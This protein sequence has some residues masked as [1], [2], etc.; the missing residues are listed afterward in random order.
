MAELRQY[1][2]AGKQADLESAIEWELAQIRR[3]TAPARRPPK[4]VYGLDDGS[5]MVVVDTGEMQI[6]MDRAQFDAVY[7]DL[8]VAVANKAPPD[9]AAVP[10][11]MEVVRTGGN[12]EERVAAIEALASMGPEAK[13]TPFLLGLLTD[14]DGQL[15]WRV[16]EALNPRPDW[17]PQMLR[18][19]T[20]ALKDPA[21]KVRSRAVRM[22]M[23]LG[24]EISRPALPAL[25]EAIQ[26]ED[27]HV[28]SHAREAV[29]LIESGLEPPE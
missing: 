28:Q 8:C 9:E 19:L 21:K 15:P 14:P 4:A 24:P 11:L 5:A 13:G 12:K 25:R 29:Q 26:D 27:D 3:L 1:S 20:A 18:V 2:H 16:L 17:T 6:V 7:G 10:R 22:L 23:R